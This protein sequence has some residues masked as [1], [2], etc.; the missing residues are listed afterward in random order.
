[1]SKRTDYNGW[2]NYSTWNVALWA[3]NDEGSYRYV[4]DHKPYTPGKARRIAAD[5]FGERTPDGA[6]LSAVSWKEIATAWNEE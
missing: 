1:M 3:D 5:L 6:R 2:H 4:Q